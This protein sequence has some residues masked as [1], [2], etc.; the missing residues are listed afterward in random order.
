MDEHED[1]RLGV[2]VKNV[3]FYGNKPYKAAV[4]HGGPGALGTVADIALELSK[5]SGV[6]EPMQTKNSISELLIELDEI[7]SAYCDKPITLIGHSWGAWLVFIYAAKYPQ[8]VRKV[9]LVGSGPFDVQY[10]SDIANNR[11]KHLTGAERVEFNELLKRLNSDKEGEKDGLLKRLGEIVNK[12]DNYCV[13]EI[14]TDKKD[15][16]PVEGDKYSAIWEE[17]A[18]LRESGKLLGLADGVS[19]PVVAIHGEHD[20]HPIDGVKLPLENKVKDFNFCTLGKCGHS[21][22]KEKHAHQEFYKILR[23]E[24]E[25]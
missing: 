14:D 6:I 19:C 4:V 18:A 2:T 22:W 13:F 7:I 9:I 12:S 5:D 10:V 11:M 8:R 24:L 17:A 1:I 23:K 3:R 16:L 25:E 21:P 15:C 20:P